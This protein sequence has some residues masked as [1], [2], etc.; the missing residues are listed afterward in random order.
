MLEVKNLHVQYGSIEALQGI[1]FHVEEGEMV[2]LLGAN[3]AGK[4]TT[5]MSVMRLGPPEGP[6]V[7][8]GTIT[9]NGESLLSTACHN[10]VAKYGIG[11]A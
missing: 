11:P 7:T 1:S 6:V 5:L 3:G 4:S 10:V 9:Y 8:R 2:A